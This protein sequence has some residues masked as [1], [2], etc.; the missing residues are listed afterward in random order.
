MGNCGSKKDVV[1]NNERVSK[2]REAKRTISMTHSAKLRKENKI[3]NT[4]IYESKNKK[5]I[6][7][8]EDHMFQILLTTKKRED[9]LM[10]ETYVR[11]LKG[12]NSIL[13][14]HQLASTIPFADIPIPLEVLLEFRYWRKQPEFEV[15]SQYKP[16][17]LSDGDWHMVFANM[18]LTR[19]LLGRLKNKNF[20]SQDQINEIKDLPYAAPSILFLPRSLR[21]L[22][23]RQLRLSWRDPLTHSLP[24]FSSRYHKIVLNSGLPNSIVPISCGSAA[25]EVILFLETETGSK[26][27]S[28]NIN[29]PANRNVI[30]FAFQKDLEIFVFGT[31]LADILEEIELEEKSATVKIVSSIL[32]EVV[33]T[34]HIEERSLTLIKDFQND[35]LFLLEL[36]LK[37]LSWII[38]VYS[39]EEKDVCGL[40]KIESAPDSWTSFPTV[41]DQP[42]TL[43]F[44]NKSTGKNDSKWY[45]IEVVSRDNY[46][47]DCSSFYDLMCC[48]AA[49]TPQEQTCQLLVVDESNTESHYEIKYSDEIKNNKTSQYNSYLLHEEIISSYEWQNALQE[50][51]TA[52]LFEVRSAHPEDLVT[53]IESNKIFIRQIFDEDLASLMDLQNVIRPDAS[54]LF[55]FPYDVPFLVLKNWLTPNDEVP[56]VVVT[57]VLTVFETSTYDFNR[58]GKG[59]IFNNQLES[60][61]RALQE[62][63][64]SH[65]E[66]FYPEFFIAEFQGAISPSSTNLEIKDFLKMN[67]EVSSGGKRGSLSASEISQFLVLNLYVFLSNHSR[68]GNV[69]LL[70]LENL[71]FQCKSV[72]GERKQVS[73]FWQLQHH[74]SQSMQ[75]EKDAEITDNTF[76]VSDLL[77]LLLEEKCEVPMTWRPLSA[78]L[79]KPGGLYQFVSVSNASREDMIEKTPFFYV[80]GEIGRSAYCTVSTENADQSPNFI[81]IPVGSAAEVS[82]KKLDRYFNRLQM[83]VKNNPNFDLIS[84]MRIC[85]VYSQICEVSTSSFLCHCWETLSSENALSI[86]RLP[87]NEYMLHILISTSILSYTVNNVCNWLDYFALTEA[88][89]NTTFILACTITALLSP[90][91]NGIVFGSLRKLIFASLLMQFVRASNEGCIKNSNSML[92]M[93]MIELFY[94]FVLMH[95]MEIFEASLEISSSRLNA[96]PGLIKWF[97]ALSSVNLFFCRH[98]EFLLNRRGVGPERNPQEASS[99]RFVRTQSLESSASSNFSRDAKQKG[100]SLFRRKKLH[101]VKSH[102]NH[103]LEFFAISPNFDSLPPDVMRAQGEPFLICLSFHLSRI[104]S[105]RMKI[106]RSC[107]FYPRG[108]RLPIAGSTS[109][110]GLEQG[111]FIKNLGRILSFSFSHEILKSLPRIWGDLIRFE[112]DASNMNLLKTEFTIRVYKEVVRKLLIFD[113]WVGDPNVSEDSKTQLKQLIK[114]SDAIKNYLVEFN[115]PLT[116]DLALIILLEDALFSLHLAQKDKAIQCFRSILTLS[117]LRYSDP[118]AATTKIGLRDPIAEEIMTKTFMGDL[119]FISRKD[120]TLSVSRR[121]SCVGNSSLAFGIPINVVPLHILSTAAYLDGD[122]QSI[123]L[124]NDLQRAHRLYF[125]RSPYA[126][127]PPPK[128]VDFES[129]QLHPKKCSFSES[130]DAWFCHQ[131]LYSMSTSHGTFV[132][133]PQQLPTLSMNLYAWGKEVIR[134]QVP[135]RREDDWWPFSQEATRDLSSVS[136]SLVLGRCLEEMETFKAR[137]KSIVSTVPFPSTNTSNVIL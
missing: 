10:S 133:P 131:L 28:F 80:I 75:E 89:K 74:L 76:R 73:R 46:Q 95:P 33:S 5:E 32:S 121:I 71:L 93:H 103:L 123:N 61:P 49:V 9:N 81:M 19:F 111:G 83:N 15:T 113:H 97:E 72:N 134:D 117:F 136:V 82:H 112:Q 26:K 109:F 40:I 132:M 35:Q 104:L 102:L 56:Y 41:L 44:Q 43:L 91:G 92:Q 88:S 13:L 25:L 84:A 4:R 90:A 87:P 23:L 68:C 62:I 50:L 126:V 99:S 27:L 14:Q 18:I 52:A 12:S 3:S 2:N 70:A 58:I 45:P 47:V 100:T 94:S 107:S 67:A 20:Q 96:P 110:I 1:L 79:I 116:Y 119:S 17:S 36:Y 38:P 64:V 105:P 11:I 34:M 115:C 39:T 127:S 98:P 124:Y 101:P 114:T 65:L 60:L 22:D 77:P 6:P 29:I 118:A 51:E 48:V 37:E 128:Y 8:V 59:I 57:P 137:F 55:V 86:S 63:W 53:G 66:M 69:F 16:I 135:G 78:V 130:P 24:V 85:K 106:Y 21:F 31:C 120:S 122:I 108:N 30:D 42:T 129:H 54:S 125:P 7:V